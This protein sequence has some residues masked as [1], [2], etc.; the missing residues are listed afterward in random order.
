MPKFL[1]IYFSKK[2]PNM[3]SVGLVQRGRDDSLQHDTKWYD[4]SPLQSGDN[5]IIW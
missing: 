5:S 4:T 1:L 3:R 2:G